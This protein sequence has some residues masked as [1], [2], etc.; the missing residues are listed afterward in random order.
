MRDNVFADLD[1]L[2]TDDLPLTEVAKNKRYT[3]SVYGDVRHQEIDILKIDP[4][5]KIYGFPVLYGCNRRSVGHVKRQSRPE[6]LHKFP[7]PSINLDY[8]D[9]NHKDNHNFALFVASRREDIKSMKH[10]LISSK[11]LRCDGWLSKVERLDTTANYTKDWRDRACLGNTALHYAAIGCKNKALKLLLTHGWKWDSLNFKKETPS[12]LV[13]LHRELTNFCL[14][15]LKSFKPKKR[16]RKKKIAY[17]PKK[18][19]KF[20]KKDKKYSQWVK[21]LEGSY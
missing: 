21:E 8:R 17:V 7:K 2:Y 16:W 18:V 19:L 14:K 6:N 13:P 15:T 10:A 3:P 5:K 9:G 1:Q 20:N 4:R 12:S 11:R